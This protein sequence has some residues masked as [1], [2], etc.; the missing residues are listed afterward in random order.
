[1]NWVDL[2]NGIEFSN[3]DWFRS[4]GSTWRD[5]IPAENL[6]YRS[7]KKI[8]SSDLRNGRFKRSFFFEGLD[9]FFYDRYIKFYR[10]SMLPQVF[11]A[12][13]DR[14]SPPNTARIRPRRSSSWSQWGDLAPHRPSS[15][16]EMSGR[17][18][19]EVIFGASNLPRGPMGRYEPR[20]AVRG[21]LQRS[22]GP[23]PRK[24]VILAVLKWPQ[25]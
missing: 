3:Q 22:C 18:V 12:G 6:M 8:S 16:S 13:R 11:P 17:R 9:I 24:V 10:L 25:L 2:Q 7:L 1:M 4:T 14:R 15:M 19:R 21:A 23:V 20:G 5:Q